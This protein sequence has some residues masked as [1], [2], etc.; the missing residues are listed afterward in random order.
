MG[1]QSGRRKHA[2]GPEGNWNLK[3]IHNQ[4]IKAGHFHIPVLKQD[5]DMLYYP[6]EEIVSCRQF[7]LGI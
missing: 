2:I 4:I 1:S 7:K 3:L 5:G 6:Y